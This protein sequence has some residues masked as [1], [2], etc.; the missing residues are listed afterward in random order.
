MKFLR[1]FY[2]NKLR[3][4]QMILTTLLQDT[5]LEFDRDALHEDNIHSLL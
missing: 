2:E 3:D 5:G 1:N 4:R